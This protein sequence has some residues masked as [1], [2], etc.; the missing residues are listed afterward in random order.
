M[1]SQALELLAERKS[2]H[3]ELARS[4]ME[5]LMSGRCTEAQIAAF[6]MG[7]CVKGET[8]EEITALAETM[9][10]LCVRIEP[11]VE[12]VLTDLVGTGGAPLKTFNVST[13]SAF[14]VAGAGLPVAKH[15]NRGITSSCGSADLLEA[16]GLDLQLEPLRVSEAIERVGIGF[17]YAPRFHPAM[18]HVAKARKELGLRTIFNL[19]GPLVNPA[20]ARAQLLG[21]FSQ[22]LLEMYP[23]VLQQLG[24][25]R[26]LVVYGLDGVDEISI[27][28]ETR[29]Y[30]L[31]RGR[32]ASLKLQPESFGLRRAAPHEIASLP[33]LESARVTR[34]LLAGRIK[35]A[36]YEMVLLNAGA[37]IYVAEAARTLEEGIARAEESL[38]SGAARKKLQR[39]LEHGHEAIH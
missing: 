21:V 5:D 9:R 12:G 33:P 26:A 27:T 23:Q 10:A 36:R 1:I 38:R 20:G 37:A 32:I 15:G 11:R 25:E 17:L 13:V 35:D 30:L 18:Q 4:A 14:V 22:E 16:L 28:G 39:L 19:L 7:L 34:E 2:L 24:I 3:R 31:S 29:A 8:A 6:L